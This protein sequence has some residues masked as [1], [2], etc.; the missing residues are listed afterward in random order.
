MALKANESTLYG[1]NIIVQMDCRGAIL[2]TASAESNSKMKRY[3]AYIETFSPPLRFQWVAGKD[4]MFQVPD[5][6]SRST[7][8]TKDQTP[9]VN[10][11]VTQQEESCIDKLANKLNPGIAEMVHF[12]IIMAYVY[13][14]GD[15]PPTKTGSIF[16]N[17]LGD[18]CQ[19]EIE[20][21]PMCGNHTQKKTE[22][23]PEL[24]ST[25]RS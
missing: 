2:V 24:H 17:P 25:N 11:K 5:M 18:V 23:P 20:G 4:K 10:K 22:T 6:L 19:A 7:A 8:N 9:V 15:S 3:L 16:M 13:S 21:W 1:A 14:L 12:P